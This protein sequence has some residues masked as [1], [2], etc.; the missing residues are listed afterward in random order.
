[1]DTSYRLC[2][3]FCRARESHILSARPSRR[4]DRSLIRWQFPRTGWVKVNTDGSRCP[5]SGRASCGGV[6]RDENGSGSWDSLDFI[7]VCSTLDAELWAVLDGLTQAW[8]LGFRK[9]EIELDSLA[10][11]R[12]IKGDATS[13]AHSH[14]FHHIHHLRQR[15]WEVGFQ[16]V[17]REANLV[18]DSM[19]KLDTSGHAG[20]EFSTRSLW[21]CGT[22][23]S[24][25][26][27]LCRTLLW[28]QM[29]RK[30]FSFP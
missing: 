19:T 27:G 17:Y 20:V 1:M 26:A 2:S 28:L 25:I 15:D 3:Q 6:I 24:M 11:I 30:C 23:G 22:F 21:I 4:V 7:G 13:R 5:A 9:V 29:R 12:I 18:A 16:H 8:E 14:L 10:A